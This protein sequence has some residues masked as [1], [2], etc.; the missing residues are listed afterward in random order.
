MLYGESISTISSFSSNSVILAS[1]TSL[2]L[3]LSVKGLRKIGFSVV[4]SMSM[5]AGS[6]STRI[7]RL[8]V[9]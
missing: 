4:S 7:C 8:S 3:G 1:K 2:I 5:M 9:A 6:P